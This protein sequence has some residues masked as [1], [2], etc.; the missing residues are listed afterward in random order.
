[1]PILKAPIECPYPRI[2][3]AGVMVHE[4]WNSDKNTVFLIRRKDGLWC[5]PGGKIEY[6]EEPIEA[7]ER[8]MKEECGVEINGGASLEYVHTK[9]SEVGIPISWVV[10]F[11][12]LDDWL[13]EPRVCE[14]DKHTDS[15]WFTLKQALEL[16]LYPG[17][18]KFLSQKICL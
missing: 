15:G 4:E 6:G 2:A 5:L 1:M 14:P 11:Y 13:N 16:D 17:C 18:R 10:L 7:I 3:V 9:I 8:E 12:R